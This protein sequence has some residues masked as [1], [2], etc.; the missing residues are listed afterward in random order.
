MSDFS[1]WGPTDDGRIKPDV[2]ADG[3]NVLSCIGTADNA[4]DTYS[5]TSMATPATTGSLLLLQEYYAKLHSGAF[6]RSATLKGIVIHTADEA[7]PADG[8]DFTFGY[9]LVNIKKAA[10]LITADTSV[11]RDQRIYEDSLNNAAHP[12]FTVSLV[13]SGKGPLVATITWTDPAGT[14][15]TS[16]LLNNTTKMLVNDLDLRI[17]SGSTTWMPYILDATQPGKAATTGD[18]ALN[19]VEKIVINNPV[20]GQTYTFTVTHKGTLAKNGQAYSLLI[21][22]V[23]GTAYCSSA[24]TSTAGTRIDNVNFSTIN[25]ATSNP[26]CRTSTD[27]TSLTADIQPNQQL[28]ITVN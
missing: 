19:N 7:G 12:S 5:G 1:S 27:Y 13:A 26:S 28:P 24:A 14:P 21:S 25:Q 10:A 4:Y 16:N 3:V 20:P 17:T 8:P 2:V 15:V 18:D 22:G 11:I 23:G 6:M 9:G